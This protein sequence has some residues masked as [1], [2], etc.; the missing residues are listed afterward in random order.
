MK[1]YIKIEAVHIIGGDATDVIELLK[2]L[3]Q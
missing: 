3:L 2:M 1:G